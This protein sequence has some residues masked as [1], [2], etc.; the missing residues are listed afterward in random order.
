MVRARTDILIF[1]RGVESEHSGEREST[2]ED[3]RRTWSPGIYAG[4][5]QESL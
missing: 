1:Y 3:R 5:S 2:Q 4:V